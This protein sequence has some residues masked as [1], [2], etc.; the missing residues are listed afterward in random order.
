MTILTAQ[1]AQQIRLAK[2]QVSHETYKQLFG[3]AL[4]LVTRRANANET[5]VIYKI[6]HYILGR[7]TINVKHAARYISEKLAIYGYKT[8]F[9]EIND[10]FYVNIDWGIEKVIVPKKPRDVKRPKV[11]DTSIQS[12]PAEAVR[13]M[14]I[15]KLALQNSM[16]K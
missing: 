3:A 14:E 12:N 5:S 15:I 16:K 8:R 9:Y 1:E 13:R 11:V 10:T 2:R 6:P 7:P 4:Q